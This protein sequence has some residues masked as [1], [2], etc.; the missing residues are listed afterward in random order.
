MKN[1]IAI[2]ILI[3]SFMVFAQT[4]SA[5]AQKPSRI[6]ILEEHVAALLKRISALEKQLANAPT[7][8]T[9][10]PDAEPYLLVVN[11]LREQTKILA[12]QV[13]AGSEP[14]EQLR[15]IYEVLN[16]Q[17]DI[18]QKEYDLK[19]PYMVMQIARGLWGL[20]TFP[21]HA[22]GNYGLGITIGTLLFSAAV[23]AATTTAPATAAVAAPAAVVGSS[24]MVTAK[25]M[26]AKFATESVVN[27]ASIIAS[28]SPSLWLSATLGAILPVNYLLVAGA[29][30]TLNLNGQM[31]R[32]N[33]VG[34]K[35]IIIATA[36][37]A[38]SYVVREMAAAPGN[39][40]RLVAGTLGNLLSDPNRQTGFGTDMP[41]DARSEGGSTIFVRQYITEG[42]FSDAGSQTL[43][44]E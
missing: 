39:V 30:T 8:Q 31:T 25:A 16:R 34:F 43:L 18:A 21:V 23:T 20:V 36:K 1:L 32:F 14:N 12:Q 41:C 29:V 38:V 19:R 37:D 2:N 4:G 26:V 24:I 10:L 33:Q 27:V 40:V 22:I 11:A 42:R 13:K 28:V 6:S 3:S 17:A 15:R 5:E 44:R 35:G 7:I 9:D